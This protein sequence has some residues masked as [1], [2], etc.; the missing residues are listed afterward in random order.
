MAHDAAATYDKNRFF[1]RVGSLMN[2]LG[3]EAIENLLQGAKDRGYALE[4]ASGTGRVS[5]LLMQHF[6]HTIALDISHNMLTQGNPGLP[7]VADAEKL[8]FHDGAFGLVT[9]LRFF[10]HLPPEVRE[11]ILKEMSRVTKR[12]LIIAYYHR[13][14]IAPLKDFVSKMRGHKAPRYLVTE[15]QFR[16]ELEACSL[17]LVETRGTGFQLS[18]RVHLL[19]RI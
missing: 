7:I 18:G 5:R 11:V 9:C 10:G 13:R 2:Q 3:L 17:R 16:R 6:E 8:P 12:H 15:E 14:A 4:V 1:G 19:E